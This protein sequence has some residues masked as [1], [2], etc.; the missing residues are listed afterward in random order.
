MDTGMSMGEYQRK[1]KAGELEVPRAL[2]AEDDDFF[3]GS[4]DES[5]GK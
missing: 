4:D 3:A 5:R 2:K 1:L